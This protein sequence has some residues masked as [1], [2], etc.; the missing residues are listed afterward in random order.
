MEHICGKPVFRSLS[1]EMASDQG[2]LASRE[3][4]GDRYKDIRTTEVTVIFNDFVLQD[5][6]VPPGVPGQFTDCPMILMK[7]VASMR[8][9][10]VRPTSSLERLEF[11]L[12]QGK[13]GGKKAVRKVPKD[14]L[15][16]FAA[17][18]KG[19]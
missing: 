7:V 11:L 1:F 4:T 15:G 13:F 18:Q 9:N 14:D 16:R 2:N 12:D 10:Q 6:L 5:Q 8:E 19:T 17:S 3:L